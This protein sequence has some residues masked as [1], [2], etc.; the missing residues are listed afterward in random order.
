MPRFRHPAPLVRA[1][2][3]SARASST[4]SPSRATSQLAVRLAAERLRPDPT[5]IV[6]RGANPRPV[7][8][9][10]L[11][12]ERLARQRLRHLLGVVA[13]LGPDRP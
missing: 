13:R 9:V 5:G 10:R 11:D 4:G 2:R 7:A 8:L 12:R 3:G 1:S 6:V